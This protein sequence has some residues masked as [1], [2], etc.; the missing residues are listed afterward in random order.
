M[1][2]TEAVVLKRQGLDDTAMQPRV[3]TCSAQAKLLHFS[4][5][6]KPWMQPDSWPASRTP[7][8]SVAPTIGIEP[9]NGTQAF[10]IEGQSVN[11]VACHEIWTRY[12]SESVLAGDE[13]D[14][15]D[16]PDDDGAA[17]EQKP[18]D[19]WK[20]NHQKFLDNLKK[21]V[22]G[23]QSYDSEAVKEGGEAEEAVGSTATQGAGA[24]AAEGHRRLLSG[25]ESEIHF[26]HISAWCDRRS[27]RIAW[28]DT[29]ALSQAPERA[30]Q[31]VLQG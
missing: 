18:G 28:V 23:E 14:D 5:T 12:I 17:S 10:R 11:F 29:R 22:D 24:G 19:A 16:L 30:H 7:L 31:R 15:D 25:P 20:S 1:S 27:Q 21:Q 3:V 26:R 8:C 13:E 9:W 2:I 4:G 6:A